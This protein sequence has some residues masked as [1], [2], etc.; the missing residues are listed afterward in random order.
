MIGHKKYDKN[1]IPLKVFFTKTTMYTL[2]PAC[3]ITFLIIASG[4][5]FLDY[6]AYDFRTILVAM[7]LSCVFFV[8]LGG[9]FLLYTAKWILDPVTELT[10]AVNKVTAGDFSVKVSMPAKGKNVAELVTLLTKFNL[11]TAE[12]DKMDYL[13]R[14]FISSV[15]HEFKTPLAAIIGF[16]DILQDT[17]LSDVER[18]EFLGLVHDEAQHLARISDSM[19][20]MA[21]LDNQEI[22]TCE[23]NIRLDELLRKCLILLTEKWETHDHEFILDLDEITIHSNLD[24]QQQLWLNLLDNAMKYSAEDSKIWLSCKVMQQDDQECI[25]VCV[26]DEGIGIESE[27]LEFIFQKFY[28][29]EESHHSTGSGLGLSIVKRIIELLHGTISCESEYGK[30]TVMTVMFKNT[31][32]Y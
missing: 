9:H 8:F 11:M 2:I 4:L 29:C 18:Q 27:K 7:V 1:K 21:R 20:N 10:E 6:E 32:N 13:R 24:M 14:D 12:L 5:Y 31:T 15:S 26:R 28:Q 17:T 25:E 19:L 16:T 30:G 22:I 3:L 23:D